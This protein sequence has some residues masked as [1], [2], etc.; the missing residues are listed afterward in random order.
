MAEQL[1]L[2]QQQQLL[3][4]RG[5]CVVIPTYNNASTVGQVVKDCLRQCRD[6]IVVNDGCTDGT[7]DILSSI[8]GITVVEYGSNRGKGYA[9]K[10]GFR[11]ALEM[12]FAYALTLDAD[13]Q[14]YASDIPLFLEAN[15]Q[16]PG[17]L[18]IGSRQLE[19]VDRSRGSSFANKFSNFWFWVQTGRALSDTQ[20]GYRLYPL[21][22]LHGL[23]LL[24]S[25]YEAELELM[26]F[27]SWHGVSLVPIPIHV[28]YP[29]REERVSHFRPAKDFTRISILNTVLCFLA[30]VYGLPLRLLRVLMVVVRTVYSLLFFLFF[31]SVIFTPLTWVY[32]KLSGLTQK[33]RRNLH[34]LIYYAARVIMIHHGV[35]GTR[36]VCR[37]NGD[38]RFDKPRIIICNHQSHL[39]L[40][41]QLVFTPKIVFL[42]N[43]WVWNNPLY[44]LLIR[45]AEYLPAYKGLDVILP[46]LRSLVARGYSVA[47]YPEGTRSRDCRIG[48]FHQGAFWL[49][50]ELQLEVL[51]MYLYGAG[52]ILPKGSYHL[53]KG[54][55]YI[56]V[57]Q[58]LTQAQLQA[59]GD[60][61][62]QARAVR[63]RYVQKYQ[64]IDNKLCREE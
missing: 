5:I 46:Q 41:C 16:H 12:G 23:S 3:H 28:Y 34:L 42:T 29:P 44:G 7:P 50:Q 53:R 52:K 59:M 17:A 55:F 10:T 63:K 13:G 1:D 47:V 27:A 64:E 32:L 51:P 6:V 30:V 37:K 8:D 19:G 22:R 57:D 60:P 14:H 36:F 21:H 18:I 9:L 38:I 62:Q 26:V 49:A 56:E 61:L 31:C 35:P 54:T 58:P 39:D 45:N 2:L 43:E 20:T 24:T 15:R 33:T 40:M 11:K 48:R 4:D 25:R